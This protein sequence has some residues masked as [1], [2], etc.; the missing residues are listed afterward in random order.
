MGVGG[1]SHT[2]VPGVFPQIETLGPV[3]TVWGPEQ[4]P[5]LAI[6]GPFC[7]ESNETGLTVSRF[8]WTF[9][10]GHFDPF[11]AIQSLKSRQ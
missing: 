1:G 2:G 5:G 11:F 9:V 10:L 6:V 4:L 7:P 8:L 3:P